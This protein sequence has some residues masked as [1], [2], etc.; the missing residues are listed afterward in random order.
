LLEPTYWE[1][2]SITGNHQSITRI[3]GE[4][5]RKRVKCA[6]RRPTRHTT[7]PRA[8]RRQPVRRFRAETPIDRYRPIHLAT[9]SRP[10]LGRIRSHNIVS[11]IGSNLSFQ[12][13]DTQEPT[14]SRFHLPSSV[15]SAYKL[16]EIPFSTQY[17]CRKPLKPLDRGIVPEEPPSPKGERTPT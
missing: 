5:R 13:V 3:A 1:E 7:T 10:A 8:R 16:K 11:R 9:A 6:C 2:L 4:R 12:T 14:D 17:A 15:I